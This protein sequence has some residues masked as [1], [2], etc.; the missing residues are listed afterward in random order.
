MSQSANI[1]DTEAFIRE[2]AAA[3]ASKAEVRRALG[4]C[5][6]KFTTILE[7]LPGLE[8]TPGHLTKSF[9]ASCRENRSKRTPARIAHTN[10]LNTLNK[11]RNKIDFEGERV[12]LRELAARL[13]CQMAYGTILHRIQRNKNAGMDS[14]KAIREALTEPSRW[15]E[16]TRKALER[17]QGKSV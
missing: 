17:K 5:H 1:C 12:N 10:R 6:R 13:G 4:L 11:E 9:V 2:Q 3:G 8:W 16:R 14:D 15:P 7:V